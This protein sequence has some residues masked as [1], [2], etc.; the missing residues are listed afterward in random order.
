MLPV[1]WQTRLLGRWGLGLLLSQAGSH[2]L[3]E[4]FW[5]RSGGDGEWLVQIFHS[6]QK[7]LRRPGFEE[8]SCTRSIGDCLDI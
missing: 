8:A 1:S 2:E 5:P 4:E 7:L 6:Y 3:V